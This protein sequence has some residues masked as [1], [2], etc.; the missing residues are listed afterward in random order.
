MTGALRS[1]PQNIQDHTCK[2]GEENGRDI[3][4]LPFSSKQSIAIPTLLLLR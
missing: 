4:G 3:Q 1:A 2:K